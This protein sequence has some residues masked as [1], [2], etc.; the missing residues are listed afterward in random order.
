MMLST[1]DSVRNDHISRTESSRI[2]THLAAPLLR[3]HA[4][5]ALD[6]LCVHDGDGA[7]AAPDAEN[8]EH[9]V[10]VNGKKLGQRQRSETS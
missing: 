5:V 7:V 4:T 3:A 10:R 9:T 1:N 6:E 2:D 8:G